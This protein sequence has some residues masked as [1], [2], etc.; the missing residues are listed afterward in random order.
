MRK[1]NRF[2]R[3]KFIT[4]FLLHKVI[5]DRQSSQLAT[6]VASMGRVNSVGWNL[7]LAV[8]RS[9]AFSL[10]TMNGLGYEYSPDTFCCMNT[11]SPGTT[12]FMKLRRSDSRKLALGSLIVV[13]TSVL[14][15]RDTRQ[16]GQ[17]CQQVQP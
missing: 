15:K 9:S 7:D 10:I 6:Y 1:T 14:G 11:A 13:G 12:R 5:V 16:V 8:C 17:G 2:T 3:R 4:Q